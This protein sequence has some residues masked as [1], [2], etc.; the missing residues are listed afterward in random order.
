MD[1]TETVDGVDVKRSYTYL[2][3][4]GQYVRYASGDYAVV[5]DGY[6]RAIGQLDTEPGLA[7]LDVTLDGVDAAFADRRNAY[8]FRGDVCHV[9]SA[10]ASRRYDDI[11]CL[12]GMSCAF[13]ENGS[14]MVQKPEGW[15]HRSSL[16]GRAVSATPFRPRTLRTVPARFR[17]GL[18]AVLTGAD[19]NTYL[20]KG[21][22]CFNIRLNREYPLAEEWGRPRNMILQNNVVDAAFVGRDGKTYLFSDDQFVV[23]P[24][25]A[26]TT[27]EGDPRPI[28]EYW[29]GLTSV[30]LAY[31]RD[32]ATYLFEK[33]DDAGQMRCVVYPGTDY[34]QPDD[35]Y[36]MTVD[37]GYWPAPGEFGIPDAVL[38]EGDTML[39]LRGR[40]CVSYNEKTDRWS[41]PRPSD[42]VWRGFNQLLSGRD[43]DRLRTAFTAADG[44]T[45]FFI[46]ERY[47][48]YADGAF[49]PPA[50]VRERWGLSR[51]PFI[52]AHGSATVDA[53]F[54]WRGEQT[55]LFSQ[56][57]YVRY[58][59]P[60]Y[61]YIDP[62]YP[63]RIAGNLRT[64]E[65]FGN[66]PESFEDALG[67]PGGGIDA[68]VA[69]DR[70]VYLFIGG[71][72]H[73]VSRTMTGTIGID[74]LGKARNTVAER[75]R[76]DAALVA[77][78]HTYLFSGD[79]YV[80]YSGYD[81]TTVDDG[82]PKSIG[83]AL[84]GELGLPP[85]P[86]EFA[87]GLDAAFRTPD[88]QT[89]LFKGK[90]FLRGGELRPVKGAWGTVR[91]AFTTGQPGVD[92][93]F[94]A[95]TGELYAFRGG[96]FIRYPAGQ[97][98]GSDPDRPV[99]A[100]EGFPRTVKDDW[101]D[102]PADFEAGPDG[103]FSFE[104]CTYLI[105][106]DRYVRYSDGRYDAVER[107]FPQEFAHRWSSSADYRLSDLHTIVRF[108]NL[109]RAHPD[110]L[111]AFLVTGAEDPYTYLSDLF[112][113]DV[114]QLR[115]ARRNSSLL[116]PGTSE[117]ARFEI[118]FL[119]K[120]V[121]AFALTD[122]LG[123]LLPEV[124]T[125]VWSK[126]Y[127][128]KPD[129]D[130]AGDALYRM[131]ERRTSAA[132]WDTQSAQI[133]NELNVL[134]RDALVPTVIDLHAEFSTSRDLFERLLDRR[135]HGQRRHHLPGA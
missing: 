49:S 42:R 20:F 59:G 11:E 5:Q 135:R 99:L 89:Y 53:A 24:D 112:G 40:Q 19:G 72:C 87:D 114:D 76:V 97:L 21:P 25:P 84:P 118:E 8:L 60:E 82:Y 78:G 86:D 38:F 6:P 124:Y 39:L 50:E 125:D 31:V 64:E 28:S 128:T 91:N 16:E 29:A 79:Q 123:A 65:P 54:V 88:G 1:V 83:D 9:V 110:G 92:A 119:L 77:D 129:V 81:Q 14:V 107:T 120:L 122:K 115:W 51:N 13:I 35:G 47:A 113:W 95:P 45:Y 68:I 111:A 106:G 18:D 70:T 58:S 44:S 98:A 57:H 17:T 48:R 15:M 71:S 102:L 4:G 66:L 73:A 37:A 26:S 109:A 10:T 94:V 69:N 100:E 116:T 103:A 2:F 96:Q 61:Q 80:R 127:G 134:K 131:L 27:I 74:T 22:S 117:E 67:G 56:D 105:K 34:G 7:A 133:H 12:P 75:Q 63:K 32:G 43:E 93:A 104:G 36:P 62:G 101:G 126:L 46:G 30:G 121:D 108:V 90:E 85:L 52:P 33:P 23:Y 41:Y 130:A 3:S 132:D 55:Y